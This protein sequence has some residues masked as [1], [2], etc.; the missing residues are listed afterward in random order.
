LGVKG[1]EVSKDKKPPKKEFQLNLDALRVKAYELKL[2]NGPLLRAFDL[3]SSAESALFKRLENFAA[4]E[5]ITFGLA[6]V[7]VAVRSGDS[8]VPLNDA[9]LEG[10]PQLAEEVVANFSDEDWNRIASEY[11]KISPHSRLIKAIGSKAERAECE[12]S[13]EYLHRLVRMDKEHQ[14]KQ[15]EEFLNRALGPTRS[16]ARLLAEEQK[17]LKHIRG[18]DHSMF[19]RDL[20]NSI[21]STEQLRNALRAAEPL[22]DVMREMS[23]SKFGVVRA[24]ELMDRDFLRM[25]EKLGR[26]TH[27]ARATV[28]SINKSLAATEALLRIRDLPA[29]TVDLMLS[30]HVAFED[31]ASRLLG[32]A[33]RVDSEIYR[34][35]VLGSVNSASKLLNEIVEISTLA[36]FNIPDMSV[37]LSLPD[38]NVFQILQMELDERGLEDE[39]FEA[40]DAVRSSLAGQLVD[41]ATKL[42]N[43]VADLNLDRERNGHQPVFKPTTEGLRAVMVLCTVVATDRDSFGKIADSLYF[44]LYE[45]S[46][47][48]DRLTDV[49]ADDELGPIWGLKQLRLGLRHDIDHGS[50]KDINKK[51]K[52]IGDAYKQLI[53]RAVPRNS[54]EWSN[55]Q[56]ELYR[57][58]VDVLRKL[59]E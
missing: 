42:V 16:L 48:A 58:L 30:P 33:N 4:N 17:A 56:L 23:E 8:D 52:K 27:L 28:E 43:L 41:L 18:F 20:S 36:A 12:P 57:S 13:L 22:S 59:W 21:A 7:D 6:L 11:L 24:F 40:D 32:A 5:H 15:R 25:A 44:L 19:L 39:E 3:S 10:S 51:A 1:P 46:A 38:L 55:T 26:D 53:G 2:P 45:G 35:N 50:A 9:T 49:L 37:V 29:P 34:V 47:T 31:F 54:A 14:R